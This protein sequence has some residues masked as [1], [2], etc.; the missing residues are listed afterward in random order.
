MEM[1][2]ADARGSRSD[3][4]SQGFLLSRFST[5]CGEFA[6]VPAPNVRKSRVRRS[7]G[8]KSRV[9]AIVGPRPSRGRPKRHTSLQQLLIASRSSWG[10]R[11]AHEGCG[12]HGGRFAGNP[13]RDEVSGRRA[14][15]QPKTFGRLTKGTTMEVQAAD[16]AAEARHVQA[17][18]DNARRE[19]ARTESRRESGDSVEISAAARAKNDSEEEHR[20]R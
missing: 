17:R 9:D 3:K 1:P 16:R 6:Q 13:P 2:I 7:D 19:E 11:L 12:G 10:K 20:E 15:A 18:R 14:P 4:I 8:S 5:H